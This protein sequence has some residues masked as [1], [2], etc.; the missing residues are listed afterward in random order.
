ML[1]QAKTWKSFHC[2]WGTLWSVTWQRSTLASLRRRVRSQEAGSTRS[3]PPSG[4]PLK[5]LTL[6]KAPTYLQ[7][8]C[9]CCI[10][11]IYYRVSQTKLTKHKRRKPEPTEI[12][13]FKVMV[14]LVLSQKKTKPDKQKPFSHWKFQAFANDIQ[15]FGQNSK[16][17]SVI[18]YP[19][20][21]K[22]SSC[23]ATRF[24]P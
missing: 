18:L 2:K 11:N 10:Q 12:Q 19:N 23:D 3:S 1:R 16:S 22:P 8:Y 17:D 13:Q 20:T 7:Q 15:C 4:R 9:E 24:W 21:L 6:K 5:T 14:C